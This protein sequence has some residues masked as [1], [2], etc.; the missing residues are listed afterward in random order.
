[1]QK[2]KI[3][4]SVTSPFIFKSLYRE[5]FD[6]L[7]RR[8]FNV[9]LLSSYGKEMDEFEN[10]EINVKR[11]N[12]ERK[13]SLISDF[14]SLFKIVI[15]F[16]FNRFDIVHYSTP[17]ASLLCAIASFVTFQR[18][19]VYTVRGRAYENFRGKK[20]HLFE[21]LEKLTCKLSTEIIFISNEMRRDFVSAGYVTEDNSRIFGLGSSNGISLEEFPETNPIEI[22]QLKQIN[23][24]PNNTKVISYVGRISIEKGIRELLASFKRFQ[25]EGSNINLIIQGKFEGIGLADVKAEINSND[26]ITY[27]PWGG[28]IRATYAMSDVFAFPSY[29]EGFGNVAIEAALMGVPVV[30]FDVIGCRESIKNNVSGLI[31]EAFS[32]DALYAGLN[33]ILTDEQLRERLSKEG[34]KWVQ[35][36]FERH[37]IWDAIIDFYSI[38]TKKS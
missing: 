31:V 24:L 34:R 10:G 33:K 36:N 35:S 3:L 28:D 32:D 15:Y 19:R 8:S 7:K 9:T 6:Y 20:R 38:I 27:R 29:R 4:F 2:T 13:V 23:G 18:N 14:I 30:A 21:F 12:I 5:H 1:M 26:A 16:L 22:R 17:K 37:Q 11:L 25:L